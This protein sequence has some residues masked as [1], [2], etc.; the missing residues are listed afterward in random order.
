MLEFFWQLRIEYFGIYLNFLHCVKS[1]FIVISLFFILVII[2][3]TDLAQL[4]LIFWSFLHKFSLFWIY[5]NYFSDC[6]II[7]K[8]L[9]Y[10]LILLISI[11]CHKICAFAFWIRSTMLILLSIWKIMTVC[12]LI[13]FLFFSLPKLFTTL[14]NIVI[15]PNYFARIIFIICI[16]NNSIF[17]L[18]C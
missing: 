7:I 1:K 4:K 11:D 8:L 5:F 15:V 17:T 12:K 10:F 18:S 3:L 6:T 2:N 13:L 14:N 9:V 16:L